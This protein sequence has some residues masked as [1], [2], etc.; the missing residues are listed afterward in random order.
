MF[1]AVQIRC[2]TGRQTNIIATNISFGK[3]P[4]QNMRIVASFCLLDGPSQ[5]IIT[6][7]QFISS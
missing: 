6:F 4:L 3:L 1:Y 7:L 2:N 5:P